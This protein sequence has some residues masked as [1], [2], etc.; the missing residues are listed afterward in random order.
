MWTASYRDVDQVPALQGPMQ[1]FER[2]LDQ[3]RDDLANKW[4]TTT[5]NKNALRKTL[6][7][8]LRFGTW[9]SLQKEKLNDVQKTD[10][11]LSWLKG[12]L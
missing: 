8:A 12:L 10:L 3:V 7:H 9:N 4:K 11:V 5:L 2:Y 1:E 6:R